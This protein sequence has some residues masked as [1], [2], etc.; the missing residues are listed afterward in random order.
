MRAKAVATIF[1]FAAS[2]SALSQDQPKY[3]DAKRFYNSLD[4]PISQTRVWQRKT[5]VQRM[6]TNQDAAASVKHAEQLFGKDVF[7]YPKASCL[8][9]ASAMQ[10]YVSALN[11]VVSS[12]ESSGF[13]DMRLALDAA[14]YAAEL[15]SRKSECS[16][17][18][19]SL[20]SKNQSST[21]K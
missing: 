19:D 8:L 15:G 6:K 16:S 5:P 11:M 17:Y 14:Y 21:K 18:V 10:N 7:A 2:T 12:A 13:A 3:E 1:L 9:A 20:D 4:A